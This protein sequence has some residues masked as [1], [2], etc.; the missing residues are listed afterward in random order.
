MRQMS[1][2][3]LTKNW[4]GTMAFCLTSVFITQEGYSFHA[5]DLSSQEKSPS[6]ETTSFAARLTRSEM[7]E[8]LRNARVLQ[9]KP[10]S[11]GVTNSQ[12]ATL[13]EGHLKHDHIQ[14]VDISKISF[15]ADRGTELNFRDCYKYNMAAY[16]LDKLLDL[17]MV[18]VSQGRSE[19][20]CSHLVGERHHVGTGSEEEEDGTTRPAPLEPADVP[21][22]GL[23]SAYLQHRPQSGQFA[24]HQRLEDMD[25]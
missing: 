3:A 8:F 5:Q 22:Q 6:K 24:D 25:D 17:N 14:T 15:Q 16:E 13:E 1:V 18:P 7:E 23:R 20:G 2:L 9:Q 12:R 21:V 10:L 4:F 19:S 11:L